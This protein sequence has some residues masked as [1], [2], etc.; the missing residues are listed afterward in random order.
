[1]E[2]T[3]LRLGLQDERQDTDL[4]T[5]QPCQCHL[6][7]STSG[8]FSHLDIWADVT[9]DASPRAD[10]FESRTGSIPR[11]PHRFP[12]V[13]EGWTDMKKG[14]HDVRDG[15]VSTLSMKTSHTWLPEKKPVPVTCLSPISVLFA[16]SWAASTAY[17]GSQARS[18][19]RAVAACLHQSHS[20]AG[21]KPRLQPTPQ[22][23]ATPDR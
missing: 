16:I 8:E 17:R 7:S 18:I 15:A 13:R 10:L 2:P 4:G 11:N 22:L 21:F 6:L 23:T 3:C 19:I 14:N 9:W 20:N 1:M 12:Q 5:C